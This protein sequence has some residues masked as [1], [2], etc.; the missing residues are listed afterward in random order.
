MLKTVT[1][2]L[3]LALATSGAALAAGDLAVK[4]TKVKLE[5]GGGE[6]GFDVEPKVIEFETGKAYKLEIEVSDAHECEWSAEDFT[7][8]VWL[9]GVEAGG[10][11]LEVFGLEEVE[12]DGGGEFEISFVPIRPGEFEWECAGLAEKGVTGKFVVK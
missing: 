9:R 2:A 4:A 12:F 7:E 10:V 5:I 8:N 11:G 3:A 1:A 6:A